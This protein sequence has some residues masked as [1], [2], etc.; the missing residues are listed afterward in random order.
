MSVPV[1]SCWRILAIFRSPDIQISDV[2]YLMCVM[3]LGVFK[4]ESVS[5]RLSWVLLAFICPLCLII[6]VKVELCGNVSCT[7][8]LRGNRLVKRLRE[9]I[10]SELT[11]CQ[12]GGEGRSHRG[13][14]E[15]AG[16][17][18]R[19]GFLLDQVTRPV[20]TEWAEHRTA[21]FQKQLEMHPPHYFFF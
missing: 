20:F 18:L 3:C 21:V 19:T 6:P 8:R 15:M 1:G 5:I 14:K 16:C 7:Q 4:M 12:T 17:G 13:V 9:K 10:W 11:W 2:I